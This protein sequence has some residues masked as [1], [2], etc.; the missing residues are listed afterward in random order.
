VAN[1]L[2]PVVTLAGLHSGTLIAVA[3]LTENGIRLARIRPADV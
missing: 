1:A 3:V 2:L